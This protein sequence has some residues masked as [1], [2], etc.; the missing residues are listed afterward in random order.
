MRNYRWGHLSRAGRA[1]ALLLPACLAIAAVR[2]GVAEPR[3]SPVPHRDVGTWYITFFTAKDEFHHWAD[4]NKRRGAMPLGGTYSAGDPAVIERQ[5]R[6]LREA[7]IDWLLMDDTNTVFVDNRAI[8]QN[9]R[10][11]FD[12][13]D[14]RPEA[15]RIPIAIAAGGELNQHGNRESWT[16]A[17]DY[18]WKTYAQR[19]SYLRDHGKPVLHWYIEKEQV[20]PDWD[21]RRWTVRKTYHFFNQTSARDNGGWAYGSD[22]KPIETPECISF[23]PGWDLSP[24]GHPRGTGHRYRYSWMRAI[25]AQ[26]RHILLSTWNGFNEGDAL[27]D[28]DA[29][30]DPSGKPAPQWYRRMTRGYIAAYKGLLLEGCY[31]QTPAGR[32]PYRF[33]NGKLTPRQPPQG[34]P[35][36][37]LTAAELKSVAKHTGVALPPPLAR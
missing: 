25:A 34:E 20:W 14:A 19:P 18:L 23:H 16:S 26:P 5:W 31:Y 37:I 21:D 1:I 10:A 35:P 27:E 36:I 4:V 7:G 30:R 8:D 12:F 29:W 17:V 11:W 32:R 6:E 15:E 33:S 22:I 28:S 13:M 24:P 3:R 2:T 9:I